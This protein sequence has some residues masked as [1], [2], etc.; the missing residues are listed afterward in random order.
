MEKLHREG[1]IVQTKP[2]AVP[3]YKRY[4]DE[5]KGVQLGSA[6]DDINP[7]HGSDRERLGYPLKNR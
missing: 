1:R 4:L 2:A 3:Q 7:L 5:G 6:W